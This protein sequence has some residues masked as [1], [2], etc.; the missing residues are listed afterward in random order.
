MAY[1]KDVLVAYVGYY[2]LNSIH[3]TSGV[4]CLCGRHTKVV[5]YVSYIEDRVCECDDLIYDIGGYEDDVLLFGGV[6][7]HIRNDYNETY[8]GVC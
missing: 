6:M 3:D 8:Y 5:I 4:T 2:R 7:Y 1:V